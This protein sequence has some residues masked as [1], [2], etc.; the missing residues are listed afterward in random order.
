MGAVIG[1]VTGSFAPSVYDA[2]GKRDAAREGLRGAFERR[3]PQSWARLLDPRL[4]LVGFVGRADELAALTAWCERNDADRLRLVTGP[5]GIGKTRLAVEL[6]ERMKKHGWVSERIAD[7]QEPAAIPALRAV[8]KA[9]ALLV[10][11]YAETRV[12]LRQLLGSLAGDLGAGVRVLLVARDVGDWWD[13][14]GAGDPASWDLIQTAAATHLRLSPVVAADLSDADVIALAVRSFARRLGL[15]ERTVEIY[16]DSGTGQRRVLDLHAAALVA[17]LAE[18]GS[19][20]VRVDIRAVLGELLRHERHYWYDSARAYGLSDGRHGTTA[21]VLRQIVAAVCLLGAASQEEA[22]LLPGRVPGMSPSST[23]AEWVRLLY[24]PD[25][26]ETDWIGSVQPDRLAELHVLRELTASPELARTCLTNLDARQGVRA[27]ALL[28]RASADYPEAES[29]LSQILP[30]VSDLLAGMEAPAE[31]LTTI[32]NAIPYPTVVLA[33]AAVSLGQRI[34]RNLPAG[35]DPAVRA[36]WLS[37][38][39]NRLSELERPAEALPVIEEA[40]TVRRELVA[41]SDRYRFDL[42][43]SLMNLGVALSELGRYAEAL[44][45]DRETVAIRK[46]LA[47]A[48]PE[49]HRPEYASALANLSQRH[50]A[51]GQYAQAFQVAEEAAVIRRELAAADPGRY[52]PHLALSLDALGIRLSALGQYAAALQVTE[53]AL[54]INRDL[55]A[56]DQDRYLP[57]LANSLHNFTISLSDLGRSAEALPAAEEALAIRRELAAASPARWRPDLATSFDNLGVILLELGRPSEALAAG[58]EAL[59]INRELAT[60]NPDRHQSDLARSLGN[61][62]AY[63]HVLQRLAEALQPIEEAV[64]IHRELAATRPLRHRP[65]LASALYSL[66]SVLSSLDRP[67]EAL[68]AAEEALA[69]RREL[70]AADPGQHQPSLAATLIRLGVLLSE[71]NRPADALTAEQ[72]AVTILREL[73]V[74]SPDRYRLDLARSLANLAEPMKLLGRPDD[75]AA[76][77]DE[78]AGLCA[79]LSN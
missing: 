31:V 41:G 15:P 73:A 52:R 14:L 62:A 61:V 49:R 32:L 70:A 3:P 24:P 5:G 64:T 40:I 36:Y 1:V 43:N 46:D 21:G 4:E 22:R 25:P 63:L 9:R 18:T 27:V 56:A 35:T 76:A 45:A 6:A 75:A 69:I 51:L 58:Q 57:D 42:S 37:S 38:L 12:G 11:D 26:G 28:A 74:I 78:S 48:E 2:I 59:V 19:G 79:S 71:L 55:A 72:E 53:E 10:V 8:T 67:A 44:A 47:A 50:F 16:G 68:R 29:L 23:I 39:G 34:T 7:G 33:P 30:N 17:V 66:S 65:G 54:T 77:L 60:G 20:A 13:Q